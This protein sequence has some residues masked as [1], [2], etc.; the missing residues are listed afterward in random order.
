MPPVA[1]VSGDPS[2]ATF[3]PE[4][5]SLTYTEGLT[6]EHLST[7]TT[8]ELLSWAIETHGSRFAVVTAFQ[9]EGMVL[10]DMAVR[11]NP[12]T[13]IVTIDTGRLPQETY[14]MMDTVRVRYG[15]RI[16]VILPDSREVERMVARHGLNL[17]RGDPSLRKLCC[18]IRKV[19][20]LDRRLESSLDVWAAGL[21]REQSAERESIEKV[22]YRAGRALKL[23]PLAGWTKQQVEE[24]VRVHD[25]P[26]HPLLE[27]GYRTVGCAP[28]SRAVLPGEDER[29]G[30]WWWEQEG[31]SKECG[32]HVMPDGKMK[33]TL[34]VLL[35]EIIH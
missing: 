11:M 29:A 25:V 31:D 21:R 33:R 13:R 24:Y 12:N 14:D 22:E 2:S 9:P 10:V 17:F 27:Q 1:T 15:A 6:A 30:R 4:S 8:E 16:E 3:I 7:L 32:I 18:Q 20:P 34:D 5:A 19:R 23:N 35:E 28:C 26:T